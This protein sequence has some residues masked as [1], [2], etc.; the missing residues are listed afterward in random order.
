V[1]FIGIDDTDNKESRGTGHM[2]RMLA[3]KLR[4]EIEVYGIT[5]HQL[6]VD[7]RIPYTA[8]NSCAALHINANGGSANNGTASGGIDLTALAE[9]VAGFVQSESAPGSDPA[10]CVAQDVPREVSEFGR[11]V[12][13][14]VVTQDEARSLAQR[15]GIILRGLGGTEDGV[16][17]A[18]A[19]VGLAAT[20]HDG[21]FVSLGSVRQLDGQQSIEAI[22]ESGVAEVRDLDDH[23]VNSGTVA[24]GGKL[25]PALREGIPI[26]YVKREATGW[27]P[28]KLD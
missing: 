1:I 7:P 12:Q 20:G 8:K 21:R 17:G 28:L 25:R 10:I 13:H 2:S 19:S 9:R 5:R 24:T 4:S 14:D 11:R 27:L 16:I 26:L 6:L 23:R 3:Q 15:H 22:L 18:L